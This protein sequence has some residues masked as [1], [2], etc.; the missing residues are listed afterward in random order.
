MLCSLRR[1]AGTGPGGSRNEFWRVLGAASFP[2]STRASAAVD[3][4]DSFATAYVNARLP[5]WFYAV[6]TEVKLIA[7]VK[8]SSTAVPP[9]F[10]APRI[11]NPDPSSHL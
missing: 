2:A 1:F 7:G 6:W 3:L 8:P 11:E 4:D 9:L 10:H 5:A